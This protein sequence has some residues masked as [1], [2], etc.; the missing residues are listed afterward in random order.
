LNG[1]DPVVFDLDG[2][3]ADTVELIRVSFRYTVL[4]VLGTEIPDDFLLAGVGQPLM[5][6]MERLSAEKS[7]ELCDVYRE[8]N[9]RVHDDLIRSYD[10]MDDALRTLRED[11]RR[12]AIVTSKGA[13]ATAMTF[14]SLGL[15]EYF[16]VVITADDCEAHKPSPVPLQ[17]CLERLGASAETA[18]YVGDAPVDIIAGRA[19]GMTTAAVMWGL[20][21]RSDLLVSAPTF[22]VSTI[23]EM[24]TLCLRGEGAR[25]G[26]KR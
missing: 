24:V 26:E 6:Q 10:G 1:F 12:L 15:R 3:V 19:A 21:S 16:D 14:D 4:A 22:E 11:G 7:Q 18:I 13:K 8:Y 2:T 17:L 23:D 25:A 9:H 5:A 20:F